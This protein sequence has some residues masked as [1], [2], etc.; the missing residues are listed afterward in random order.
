MRPAWLP[1]FGRGAATPSVAAVPDETPLFDEALLARVR[2]LVL[3]SGRVR[4][5]GLAGEHRSRRR[6][7]SPEFADF[8]NYSQGDDFRRIDWNTYGRLDNLFVRLS[9]VTTELSVHLLLDCSDSM[10]WRGDD[11]TTTK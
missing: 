2:R 7:A 1:T 6:G 9:E 4:T 5:E 8:K 11:Q 3:L 10:D